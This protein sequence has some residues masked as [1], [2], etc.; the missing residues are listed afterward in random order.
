MTGAR[1]PGDPAVAPAD[2]PR[3]VRPLPGVA[4]TDMARLSQLLAVLHRKPS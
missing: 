2:A 4:M 3:H 1:S